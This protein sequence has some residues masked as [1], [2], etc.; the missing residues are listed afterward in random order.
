MK[1]GFTGTQEGMT[2]PQSAALAG[3]LSTARFDIEEAHHGDCIGADAEFHA[4]VR[5]WAPR[6]LIVGHIPLASDRRAFC[7]FDEVR[8]P[9]EYLVRNH[10]IVDET[11]ILLA[12]PK[13]PETLRS[14]TWATIRYARE[15]LRKRIIFWP[16]G[17]VETEK[18]GK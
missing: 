3:Y 1:I 17:R 13:G 12:A 2:G 16:D 4:H 14:G 7:N 6:A 5:L 18:G 10:H 9:H 11:V 15:K 8:E